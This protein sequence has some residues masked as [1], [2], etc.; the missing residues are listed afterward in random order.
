VVAATTPPSAASRPL[1]EA[2]AGRSCPRERPVAEARYRL[3]ALIR[4]DKAVSANGGF[5]FARVGRDVA[6]PPAAHPDLDHQQCFATPESLH[7]TS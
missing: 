3:D 2:L 1:L 7:P 4:L 6:R 5:M